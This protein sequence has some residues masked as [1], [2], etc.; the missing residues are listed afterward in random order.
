MK[1]PW[2]IETERA[3][4]VLLLLGHMQR[5]KIAGLLDKH[6]P[7]YGNRKCL[8]GGEVTIVV[9]LYPFRGESPDEPRTRMAK[10]KKREYSLV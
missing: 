1:D 3:D 4:D 9:V 5:I 2:K 8:S 6:I 10:A 7:A